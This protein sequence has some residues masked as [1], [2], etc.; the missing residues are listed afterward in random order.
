MRRKSDGRRFNTVNNFDT[1]ED[2]RQPLG[3]KTEA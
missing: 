2:K 3:G 1:Q